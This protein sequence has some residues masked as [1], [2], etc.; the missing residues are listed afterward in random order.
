MYR[1]LAMY[2]RIYTS[3]VCMTE[4]RSW[5]QIPLLQLK[6]WNIECVGYVVV[7]KCTCA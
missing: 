6:L 7:W 1:A 3:A 5:V 2:D 4:H